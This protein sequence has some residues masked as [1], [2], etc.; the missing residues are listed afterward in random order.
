MKSITGPTVTAFERISKVSSSYCSVRLSAA[1]VVYKSH[2]DIKPQYEAFVGLLRC[3][4]RAPGARD[5]SPR[6]LG[7]QSRDLSNS[8]R[9]RAAR[10]EDTNDRLLSPTIFNTLLNTSILPGI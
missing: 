4:L 7:A 3:F 5:S 2:S 10:D 1:H 9:H 8:L 6:C